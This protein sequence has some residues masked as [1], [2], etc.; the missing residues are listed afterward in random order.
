MAYTPREEQEVII[1][2]D[3][4]EEKWYYY[5]DVP[6]LN[7]KWR[8]LIKAEREKVEENGQITLLEG[9]IIG[10]VSLSQKRVSKMTSQQ[11][12]EA[13]RR[14]KEFR[15]FQIGFKASNESN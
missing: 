6:P 9:E 12:E 14:M 8:H 1:R 4:L 13:S 5:G 15:R 7:R 3:R 11:R 2:L 10:N